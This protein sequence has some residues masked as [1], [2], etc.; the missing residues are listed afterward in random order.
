MVN[1]LDNLL[2]GSG[3]PGLNELRQSLRELFGADPCRL[4]DQRKLASRRSRVYRVRI[5][6]GCEVRSVVIK[7]L[8]PG[9]AL[10]NQFVAR[11]WLPAIGLGESGP[12]LMGVAAERNGRCVW[13]VYE[14]LGDWE[15]SASAPGRERVKA[16]VELI[17]QIHMRFAGHLLL[18]E[19][20]MYGGDLG[21]P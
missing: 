15:L 6:T 19:C 20:R 21:I 18:P 17:A 2:E 3:E 10:R 9:I 7:R 13:H 1:G 16:A 4:I 12:A 8:E 14:D 5:E 11:R